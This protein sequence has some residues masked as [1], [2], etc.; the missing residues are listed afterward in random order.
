MEV[1]EV[2]KGLVVNIDKTKDNDTERGPCGRLILIQFMDPQDFT[3]GRG[4]QMY[5]SRSYYCHGA[6]VC[7]SWRFVCSVNP[8]Q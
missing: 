2:R 7:M 3:T 6:T 4:V 8:S 5:I 1:G